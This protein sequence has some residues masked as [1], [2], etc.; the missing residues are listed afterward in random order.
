V[1]L[2]NNFL[3]KPY[4]L[5]HLSRKIRAALEPSVSSANRPEKG[6]PK[7]DPSL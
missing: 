4:T 2:E 6:L 5:K 7:L 3:Q 1:D